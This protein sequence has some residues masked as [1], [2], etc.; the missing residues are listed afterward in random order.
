MWI[1]FVFLYGLYWFYCDFCCKS[2]LNFEREG[3]MKCVDDERL[4]SNVIK[5]IHFVHYFF[6]LM[7][8]TARVQ[9]RVVLFL[10]LSLHFYRLHF[11]LEWDL[12]SWFQPT[13]TSDTYCYII[14]QIE[15]SCRFTHSYHNH[16]SLKFDWTHSKSVYFGA[17]CQNVNEWLS[18]GY[19]KRFKHRF[20]WAV[21]VF[22]FIIQ[23]ENW[24]HCLLGRV[25]LVCVANFIASQCRAHSIKNSSECGDSM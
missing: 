24:N 5:F 21:C 10:S 18:H 23:I 8:G 4:Y 7:C 14:T 2:K 20:C 17:H 1:E 3:W 11:I 25:F 9:H 16:T 19:A 15:F 12:V 22:Y 13:Q 6:A